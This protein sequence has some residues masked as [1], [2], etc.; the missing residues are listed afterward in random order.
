MKRKT[1]GLYD[2][3]LDIIGGGERH[4]LSILKVLE[5]EYD[6][7]VFWNE[8]LSS[9]ISKQLNLSFKTPIQFKKDIFKDKR[10]SKFQ[11]TNE[12]SKLDIFIY[13]TDGSYF[14]CTAKK[15]IVFALVPDKNLFKMSMMNKIK[16]MNCLFVTNSK[17]SQYHLNTWGVKAEILY[18]YLDDSLLNYDPTEVKK[19]KIILSVGRFFTQLHAKRQDIMIE[20]FKR[21]KQELP[22]LKEY[23]L[24]LAGGL[25]EEDKEYYQKIENMANGDNTIELKPNISYDD[26]Q[27]LYKQAEI[28]WH[29]TG[30]AVDED[31]NPQHTEHLGITPL[32][33]MSYGDIAFC[34]KAGGL[35]ETVQDELTGYLFSSYEELVKKLQRYFSNNDHKEMQQNAKKFINQTFSYDVFKKNVYRLFLNK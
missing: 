35:K 20:Y 9:K 8:N 7:V 3:Y 26:L 31:K 1:A 28:Y 2:P 27:D 22:Q 30:Y 16:M 5:D 25:K 15:N 19:E 11:K 10:I 12:L 6:P 17:F 4:A 21:M 32:E 18:P 34:Y 13:M 33:A 29:F 14:F 23:K 24:V